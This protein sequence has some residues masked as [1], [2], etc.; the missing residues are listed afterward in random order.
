MYFTADWWVAY[1]STTPNLQKFAI[2]V[3]SLT[4]SSSGCERNWS[5]FQ[6]VSIYIKFD[7]I[8]ISFAS[9]F[10]KHNMFSNCYRSTAKKEIGWNK[11]VSMTW[12]S[13]S[14]TGH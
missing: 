4:C 9:L 7:E 2:R 12:C 13:S 1:G 5:V 14:I 10:I 3:L 6:H 11:I 8:V